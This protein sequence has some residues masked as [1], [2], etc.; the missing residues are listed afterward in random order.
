V[1]YEVQAVIGDSD[2]LRDRAGGLTR[3]GSERWAL[4]SDRH[5]RGSDWLR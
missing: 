2:L 5:R 1:G 3:L 4:C